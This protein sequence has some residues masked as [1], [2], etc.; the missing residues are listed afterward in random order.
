[1]FFFAVHAALAFL[2]NMP[3]TPSFSAS[4]RHRASDCLSTVSLKASH[5]RGMSLLRLIAACDC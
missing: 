4:A 2:S 5:T 1:M 3:A